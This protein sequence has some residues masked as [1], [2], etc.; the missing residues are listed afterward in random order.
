MTDFPHVEGVEHRFVEAGG[1]RLHV[2]E[3][4]TG[5]PLLLVHGWPQHWYEWRGLVAELAGE[6]R[7]IMPDLRG[8]GWS[9]V[10]DG[11]IE[12]EV[13]V[14][15]LLAL[16]DALGLGQVDVVGHDWGGFSSLL[17]S[18][19]HPERV[20][21]LVAVSAPSPWLKVTPQLAL[22]T[23]RAWYAALFAAGLMQ[24]DDGRLAAWFMRREGI[25]ADD[26]EVFTA[27]LR[28]PARASAT[29]RLYRASLRTVATT[30]RGGS[31]PEPRS[32]VPT[33]LMIGDRDMAVTPKLAA[34][35][36]AAGEDLRFEVVPGAGHFI[37]DTHPQLVAASVRE[38]LG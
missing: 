36:E 7:L 14:R 13:F 35:F 32:T 31:A 18:A 5:A 27:R 1:V 17:L 26:V 24:H 33:L 16:L 29:T 6:R 2:A 10:P 37:C 3:A 23:W 9:D 38:H 28:E 11:P 15:D 34:G 19:R 4:G 25:P 12:P 8:F 21:R 30:A 22:E 20:R